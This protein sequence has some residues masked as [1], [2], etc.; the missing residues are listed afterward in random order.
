MNNSVIE[1]ANQY[2]V[3][4]YTEKCY[5]L[6]DEMGVEGDYTLDGI[7]A[8]VEAW[9]N[10]KSKLFELLRKHPN[11]N[12]ETK[13]IVFTNE[14]IRM[15]DR[16]AYRRAMNNLN[17]EIFADHEYEL[18][19]KYPALVRIINDLNSRRK[20]F[21][22]LLAHLYSSFFNP[23]LTEDFVNFINSNY[24][25]LYE[26]LKPKVG[27]KSSRFLNKFF[28]FCGIDKVEGYNKFFAEIA[29]SLNA[30]KATKISVLSVN[31]LDFMTMSNGNSWSSCHSLINQNGYHGEYRAGCAGYAND[32]VTMLY[33]TVD[34][35]YN[36]TEYYKQRKITRQVF[37]YD[38][39]TLVQERLYPKCHDGDDATADTSLV[40]QYRDLVE[41]I[42]AI[43][44][45]KPNLWESANHVIV[46]D[47]DTAIFMYKDWDCYTNWKVKLKDSDGCNKIR[48]G[49]NCYCFSTGE[50]RKWESDFANVSSLYC[51][52]VEYRKVCPH[53]GREFDRS[54]EG[55]S[56]DGEYYC[57]D[58]VRY[59]QYHDCY[60]VI[61]NMPV[62]SGDN[63]FYVCSRG[64]DY[65]MRTGRIYICDDCGRSYP[66][67]S[68]S[69][70]IID[71]R[72][73]CGSCTNAI[74]NDSSIIQC[75]NCRGMHTADYVNEHD[76]CRYCNHSFEPLF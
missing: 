70:R 46:S 60:E 29:D 1:N 10:N 8:N 57:G 6:F 59:C 28:K 74:I 45:D 52:F 55:R 32:A 37:F 65:Y 61:E 50:E 7:R 18:G 62:V 16:N 33:Y 17:N 24:P 26:Q 23:Q 20:N 19:Y 9:Y 14:E 15:P 58:C 4:Y 71:G 49:K 54:Q 75:N 69:F 22:N 56:I 35:D 51:R 30:L 76:N 12:E 31:F 21:K 72:V 66:I 38:E 40:K 25:E 39:Y 5:E 13:A 42:I 73:L 36:G 67:T 44:E 27:Q 2:D 3:N 34:K 43:C 41:H 11:W 64:Y 53:C 63:H 48:V 47:G 68:G